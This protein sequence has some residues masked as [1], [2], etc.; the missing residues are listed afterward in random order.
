MNNTNYNI[1]QNESPTPW[2]S[3][4]FMLLIFI[5]G[6]FI[7]QFLGLLFSIIFTDLTLNELPELVSL[8][9]TDNKWLPIMLI[10]GI[11]ALGGFVVA[12]IVYV[13]LIEKFK[14][15]ELFSFKNVKVWTLILTVVIVVSFMFANT[16]LIEWNMNISFPDFM[17]GFESW[18][19]LKEDELKLVTDFI[20][21]FDS[22][23]RFILGFVV[24]AIIPAIGEELIFRGILQNKLEVYFK[25][26]HLAIIVSSILFSGFHLQF[27]GFI[28]RLLLGILFGYLYYWSRS[29]WYPILA[30]LI[31]NGLTL[32]MI[33]LYQTGRISLDIE[34]EESYPANVI[35]IFTM[36]TLYM[37]YS[38]WRHYNLKQD[39]H[40]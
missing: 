23:G 4:L 25:N 6:L 12:G 33:Y 36:I 16:V 40:E 20:T 3:L 9:F 15:Y 26:A 30:H 38:F 31:N 37:L 8:P 5:A 28:P 19:R 11:G 10:Q 24:I 32:I 1:F 7:G 39:T 22:L 21:E 14:W 34:S 2:Y 13:M 35:L 18:A 29:L 27:Y 17:K